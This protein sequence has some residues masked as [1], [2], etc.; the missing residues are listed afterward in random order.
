VAKPREPQEPGLAEVE[1]ALSVLEGRHPEHERAR[2]ETLT[3]AAQRQAALAKEHAARARQRRRRMVVL[4]LNVLAFGAAAHVGWRFWTR[5]RALREKLDRAEG[6]FAEAGWTEIA[7]NT[8]AARARLD[9]NV[10]AGS[11]AVAVSSS[12]GLLRARAG[13]RSVEATHAVGFCTCE[14][15]VAASVE[16]QPSS[17]L[18][19]VG[20]AWMQIDARAIGGPLA[21]SLARTPSILWGD[22]GEACADATFDAW[23]ADGR[24]SDSGVDDAWLSEQPARE[25]L[26]R[27]GFHVAAKVLPGRPFAVVAAPADHCSLAVSDANERLSLRVTGGGRPI[28][29]VRGSL[30]WC[31]SQAMT[32]TVWREGTSSVVVLAGPATA[33]GGLLGAREC[34]AAAGV[35]VAP[36]AT[37]LPEPDLAWEAA[38]V[39][40]ASVRAGASTTV[41]A[42]A[43]PAEPGS[44]E[45]GLA[46]LVLSARALVASDPPSATTACD[47]PLDAAAVLRESVC[48]EA[49]PVSWWR[50]ADAPAAFSHAPLPFWLAPLEPLRDPAALALVPKLLGLARRLGADGFAPT[51]L[52]GVTE[53]A[54]GIHVIGRAN[55]DAI[56]AI[57]LGPNDPWVFPFANDKPWQLGQSPER[58]ALAPGQSVKLTASPLPN[59]PP[60]K[61]RTVVFRRDARR[62]PD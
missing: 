1:R 12:D 59:A 32:A 24:T 31:G 18:G 58:V 56:V 38:T 44:P 30:A 39:L 48:I 42:S 53:V 37:W 7:T 26:R 54:D 51:L 34:A 36:E 16:A 61:R 15:G 33:V 46:V 49:P 14:T 41:A 45:A 10:P 25:P 5:A 23:L 4:A 6:P 60:E 35:L 29:G 55:E 47:P 19:A 11:C 20:I 3:A 40:R 13:G 43:V 8:L 62:G 50:R 22:G 2:R 57:G 21:R 17:L 9:A 52:E 27:A 28:S